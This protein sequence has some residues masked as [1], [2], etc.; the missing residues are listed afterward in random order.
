MKSIETFIMRYYYKK[1]NE[2][3]KYENREFKEN[4]YKYIE[5]YLVM[6]KL[7]SDYQVFFSESESREWSEKKSY[8]W[9]DIIDLLIRNALFYGNCTSKFTEKIVS[10][11]RFYCGNIYSSINSFLREDGQLFKERDYY[12]H[13]MISHIENFDYIFARK[14][15]SENMITFRWMSKSGFENAVGCKLKEVEPGLVYKDKA[16]LSTSKNLYYDH[17][18]KTTYDESDGVVLLILKVKNGIRAIDVSLVA[19]RYDEAEILIDKGTKIK[20]IE[21]VVIKSNNAIF[22]GELI[23]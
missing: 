5:D 7:S 2:P 20:I 15:I 11:I 14:S 1:I 16:Y 18:N 23:Q 8:I 12:Y 22:V 3:I 13:Q 19:I 4:V 21:S 9:D 17:Y 6:K 10:T